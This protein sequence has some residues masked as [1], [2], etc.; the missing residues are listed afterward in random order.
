MIRACRHDDVPAVAGLLSEI[1]RAEGPFAPVSVPLLH[2]L[3]HT[4]ACVRVAESD[5]GTLSGV[6]V[7]FAATG[8]PRVLYT[9]VLGVA[10]RARSESLGTALTREVLHWAHAAGFTAVEGTFDPLV[11]RNAHL[12]LS[13]LGAQ[14]TRYETDLYG[15]ID[16]AINGGQNT[17]RL[18]IRWD[19]DDTSQKSPTP[20]TPVRPIV[21][22]S[23][24][25]EP[26]MLDVLDPAVAVA[27]PDDIER[28]RIESPQL[29]RR[30][31]EVTRCALSRTSTRILAFDRERGYLVT[32]E[33]SS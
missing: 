7:A 2:A 22:V 25:G 15:E 18:L 14:A 5:D 20:D 9:H 30:W 6:V 8:D 23:P 29:A 32:R 4:G 28:I 21:G 24:D 26:T 31:R 11:S 19:L 17:D 3:V 12:Y 13:V 27:V 1:W 10:P 16:D 33:R